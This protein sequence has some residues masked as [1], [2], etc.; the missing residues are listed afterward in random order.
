MDFEQELTKANILK[1][2]KRFLA[3]V[4]L[5]NQVITVHVPNT[6]SMTSCW[7]PGQKVL[8][9]HS[10]NPKRKLPYTLEMIHNGKTW[11]S[12]NTA[13]TNKIVAHALAYGLIKELTG[14]QNIKPE[15]KFEQSR[16]DFF[17][18]EHAKKPDCWVEVKNVTL[19]ENGLAQFPDAVSTR[20]QKHLNDLIKIVQN[21][22][23]A[24]MLYVVN[25]QDA[26]QFKPATHIDPKY[27]ELLNEAIQSGVEVLCYQTQLT[28]KSIVINKSIPLKP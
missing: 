26:K 13:R 19:K 11:I 12:V 9:S 1:R 3:D 14:Y 10:S 28:P 16:I 20:G 6:G 8:L 24:V 25:R 22:Q 23:R 5:D 2:Y 21:G 18:S 17:L 7:E 27:S 4:E 15:K